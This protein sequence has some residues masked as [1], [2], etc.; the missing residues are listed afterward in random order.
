MPGAGRLVGGI[1]RR[2]LLAAAVV[3]VASSG[4]APAARAPATGHVEVTPWTAAS[5]WTAARREAVR[6]LPLVTLAGAPAAGRPAVTA[7]ATDAEASSSAA[8]PAVA[9]GGVDTGDPTVFPNR[10]NGVVYGEYVTAAGR[11]R[12]QCSG[13]VI[14]SAAGNLVLTAGHCVIDPETGARATSLAFVPGYRE[15][16][17]PYGIWGV[18]RYATT[19]A[20]AASAGGPNPDEGGDLAF[21]V[22]AD[23]AEG[24]S[25]EEKV[26][27][28]AIAFDQPREQTYTQWGYPAEAP[29]D[30]EILYSNNAAYGGPDPSY[31][32]PPMRIASDFTGGSSGGPWTVEIGGVPTVLSLTD[33]TYEALPHSIYG[34][35]LGAAARSTYEVA[36]GE[37][38]PVA[39]SEAA[40]PLQTPAPAAT[41][42][43]SSAA[44]AAQAVDSGDGSL[45]VSSLRRDPAHGT[46]TL[47]VTVGGPGALRLSGAA[48]RTTKLAA[49]SAGTYRLPIA[50]TGHNSAARTLRRRGTATVAIW[51]RFAGTAGVRHLSRLVRLKRGS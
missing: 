2:A 19:E 33:Y 12:Y 40:S 43:S 37:A 25:V 38:A 28:L 39:P 15:G 1:A 18:S 23:D 21:L 31:S 10:A 44:A 6:P 45:R 16:A 14:D 5:T 3:G 36:T 20:W 8:A 9:A 4:A 26:G 34:A 48:V 35:Y 17:T 50:L 32:P 46:A 7:T 51:V 41:A 42:A 22:L 11:E 47:T 13:S 29:Y 27:A 30:G 49:P 24:A